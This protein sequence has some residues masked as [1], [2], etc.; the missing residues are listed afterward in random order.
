MGCIWKLK[1]QKTGNSTE[2]ED[3]CS[4]KVPQLEIKSKFLTLQE[5]WPTGKGRFQ[6]FVLNPGNYFSRSSY[7][8]K[9]CRQL[10]WA[11]GIS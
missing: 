8:E 9:K 4:E 7:F 3:F 1:I 10:K 5:C 11:S 6:L 2:K